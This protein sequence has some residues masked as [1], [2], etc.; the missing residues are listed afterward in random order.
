MATSVSAPGA[1]ELAKLCPSPKALSSP[2]ASCSQLRFIQR[3]L[4][5]LG[6]R[7]GGEAIGA[8][9]QQGLAQGLAVVCVPG[10]WLDHGCC[11]HR[12]GPC[13]RG[14]LHLLSHWHLCPCRPSPAALHIVNWGW[15][16]AAVL[17]VKCQRRRGEGDSAKVTDLLAHPAGFHLRVSRHP[18]ETKVSIV[19]SSLQAP[20]C[21]R[22]SQYPYPLQSH[23]CSDFCHCDC[24]C[25]SLNFM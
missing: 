10:W 20:S 15:A 22:P 18:M 3:P 23:R 1:G 12:P 9:T 7:R 25:P 21:P 2:R 4:S 11:F 5:A 16:M 17:Q 14:S 8:E 19:S 24:F 6:P 13:C